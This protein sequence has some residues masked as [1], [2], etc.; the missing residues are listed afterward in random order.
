MANLQSST[1]THAGLTR[2]SVSMTR[3][4]RSFRFAWEGL[5]YAWKNETN[6]RV[7]TFIGIIAISVSL[8]LGVGM[9]PILLCGTLVLALELINSALEAAL[10]LV[11][12]E[13]HPLAK[14]VKDTAAA[15]VLVT[16]IGAALVGFWSL[17]PALIARVLSWL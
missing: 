4:L 14:V 16:S 10:D 3:L 15:A 9:I 12:P 5:V 1:K 6:F 2:K 7:E 11:S 13:Y 17:G 8:W